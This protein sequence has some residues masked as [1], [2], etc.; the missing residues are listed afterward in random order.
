MGGGTDA[1]LSLLLGGCVG[2]WG[3]EIKDR[4][5][6]EAL[7]GVG[8]LVGGKGAGP[9]GR[10]GPDGR[11]AGD[12]G[13][14]AAPAVAGKDGVPGAIGGRAEPP[15]GPAGPLGAGGRAGPGSAALA[16]MSTKRPLHI[17]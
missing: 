12:S 5:D 11:G 10:T 2:G 17:I 3:G 7:G 1:P 9:G 13:L 8:D 14:G 15:G 4:V 6:P 16:P